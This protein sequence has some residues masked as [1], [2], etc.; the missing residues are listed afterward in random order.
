MFSAN[1]RA[2]PQSEFKKKNPTVQDVARAANVSTATVS[3]ALTTPDRVSAETRRRVSEAVEKT[4]YVLNHAA[5]NLRRRDTGTI[6]ALVPD[7]GNSHFSNI[8]QGIETVCAEKQLK[9]L[10]ADTRKPSMSHSRVSDYFSKNNCDGIVILDGH[11]SISRIRSSNPKAPPIVLAGEWS[12]DPA[13]PISVVDN[14]LGAELAVS[15]LLDLKHTNIGHVTG[16]LSHKPGR[17]RRDGFRATLAGAGFDP[18]KAWIFEGDYTLDAGVRAAHAWMALPDRPTAVFC[19]SDRTAFG[20]ISA[21]NEAGIRVPEDVSVVGFDDIDI[22]GHYLPP[23]TT[24]HQPRRAVGEQAAKLLL[25]LL[26]GARPDNGSVQLEPWL[27]V[28]KS[29]VPLA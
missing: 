5:R 2:M 16:L 12:D 18:A 25:N 21:L 14:L 22:A 4:G 3:R 29:A 17:D 28:R 11:F 13:V 8:L 24:I 26:G 20:F 6:V 9:V 1:I 7:I 10:I 23:L 27:V 15:H 19:A